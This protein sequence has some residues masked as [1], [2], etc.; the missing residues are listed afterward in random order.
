MESIVSVTPSTSGKAGK[1]RFSVN[2]TNC[3]H[4]LPLLKELISLKGWE[5]S[6]MTTF[7]SLFRRCTLKINKLIS[8][9]CFL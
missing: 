3:R 2:I 5:V 9:G 6:E 7:N 4:E 8:F 1:K